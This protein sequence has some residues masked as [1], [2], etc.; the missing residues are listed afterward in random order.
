MRLWPRRDH[1]PKRHRTLSTFVLR[2]PGLHRSLPEGE[3]VLGQAVQASGFEGCGMSP[4][5]ERR[6]SRTLFHWKPNGN[7]HWTLGVYR[8]KRNGYDNRSG[9]RG[10][11]LRVGPLGH[12]QLQTYRLHLAEGRRPLRS[13]QVSIWGVVGRRRKRSIRVAWTTR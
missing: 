3:Q 12:V 2:L 10:L 4:V 13:F 6:P 5:A 9:H 7:K 8:W 11:V 1:S